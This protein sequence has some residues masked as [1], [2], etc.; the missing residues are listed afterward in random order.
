MTGI[1]VILIQDRLK[2]NQDVTN[3]SEGRISVWRYYLRWSWRID[4][5]YRPISSYACIFNNSIEFH[6]DSKENCFRSQKILSMRF[7]THTSPKVTWRRGNTRGVRRAARPRR[8]LWPRYNARVAAS[9]IWCTRKE[10][11]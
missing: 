7:V 4:Y 10:R 3:Q 9:T 8:R 5:E 2:F 11:L 1:F 6:I